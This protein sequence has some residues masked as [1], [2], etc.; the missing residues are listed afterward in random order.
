VNINPPELDFVYFFSV[1]QDGTYN[2]MFNF[3]F[4][5]TGIISESETAYMD[6]K[7]M[8]ID[9]TSTCTVISLSLYLVAGAD[10]AISGHFTIAP[11]FLS[12]SRGL[13][14][15][16]L[17]F[18]GIGGGSSF[19]VE[20]KIQRELE[21]PVYTTDNDAPI[22]LCVTLPHS[23]SV[24]QFFPPITHMNPYTNPF[25]GIT[26]RALYWNFTYLHDSVTV[27]YADQSQIG[28]YQN[29]NFL[30]GIFIGVGSSIL[31][32]SVYDGIKR[33]SEKAEKYV[34]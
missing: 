22:Q 20:D 15:V 25:N 5:V 24:T 6:T 31:L 3:P 12:G 13:Y 7:N 30:S 10:E 33:L 27:E 21:V 23:Y 28:Y 14:T 4:R 9:S 1:P 26:V 18:G 2:F 17:P 11:T 34:E 29:L 16:V 8:S 19:E 32:S